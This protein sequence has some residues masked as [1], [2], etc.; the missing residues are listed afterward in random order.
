MTKMDSP[1]LAAKFPIVSGV[2]ECV[3]RSVLWGS[4]CGSVM[5][6][7]CEYLG[8]SDWLEERL[9]GREG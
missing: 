4:V 7:C 6:V 8:M 3:C 1:S 9:G 2:C 5:C